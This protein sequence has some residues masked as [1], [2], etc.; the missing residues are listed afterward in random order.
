[1]AT[2]QPSSKAKRRGDPHQGRWRRARGSRARPRA[3][4]KGGE[5]ASAAEQLSHAR[6]PARRRQADRLPPRAAGRPARA[7]LLPHRAHAF[8]RQARPAPLAARN[9]QRRWRHAVAAAAPPPDGA[10]QAADPDRHLRLDE[11]AHGGLSQARACR[12]ARRR[13]RRDLHLRHAADPHHLG[14]A[15]PRPRPGAGARR[16]ARSTTGT[17]ARASA[18]R[19]SPSCRCRASPPSRAAPRSSSCRTGW[20]AATMPRWRR[21]CAG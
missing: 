12:R 20:S 4:E 9:R 16:R 17:A 10:A 19:C 3:Q 5:L 7:P 14:A 2:A 21:R 13:P 18:R 11:A 15:H 6:F 8:A 1:M